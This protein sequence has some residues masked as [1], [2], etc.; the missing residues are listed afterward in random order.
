MICFLDLETE[1][2]ECLQSRLEELDSEAK[3]WSF[4]DPHFTPDGKGLVFVAYDNEPYRLGL[5]YCYQRASRLMYWNF[6]RIS[7]SPLYH[8]LESS[9]LKCLSHDFHAVRW[10]RFSPDN[11]KI[12]WFE[13]PAG[14]PHGQCFSLVS[15]DW[16][17]KNCESK[18]I[19]PLVAKPKT[20]ADFPGICT[21]YI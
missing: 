14:G 2:V 12:I 16:P 9:T 5:I 21:N 1:E 6:G 3:H 17:P 20:L 18:V 19:V 7:E 15:L 10:P 13:V 11:C 8:L 4:D